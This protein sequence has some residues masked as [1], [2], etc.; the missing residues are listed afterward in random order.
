MSGYDLPSCDKPSYGLPSCDMPS[1]NLPSCDRQAMV[2]QA[3][4]W[5]DMIW[6]ALIFGF[7]IR[8]SNLTVHCRAVMNVPVY[9][10]L[11]QIPIMCHGFYPDKV[12]RPIPLYTAFNVLWILCRYSTRLAWGEQPATSLPVPCWSSLSRQL[13]G[14]QIKDCK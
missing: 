9:Y 1:Y 2:C 13:P 11:F 12:W 14:T 8:D 5:Q 6:Q 7:T 4:T 10:S 3:L